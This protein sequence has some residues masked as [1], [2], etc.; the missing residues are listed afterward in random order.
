MNDARAGAGPTLSWQRSGTD[1]APVVALQ[2]EIDLSTSPLL[3]S[4]LVSL[5]D[6]GAR[7]LTVDMSDVTFV[8]STGLGVLVGALQL[9]QGRGGDGLTVRGVGPAVRRVFELTG[10]DAV[11]S[12]ASD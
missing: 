8:D 7:R 12:V 11:F 2:G 3:R 5:V 9:L 10:L 1:E 4:T 6:A